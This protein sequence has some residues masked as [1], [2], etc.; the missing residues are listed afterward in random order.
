MDPIL[1]ADFLSHYEM[2]VDVKYQK[3]IYPSNQTFTRC[4]RT[5]R[6]ICAVSITEREDS[7]SK[8][9]AKFPNVIRPSKD[10]KFKYRYN[11]SHR[12]ERTTNT[13]KNQKTIIIQLLEP[14]PHGREEGQFM[15]NMWRLSN[16]KCTHQT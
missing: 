9:I 11:A 13:C 8:I 6:K 2:Q 4:D 15:D 12:D 3:L 7:F 16:V 14:G 5:A 10:Y 1:G